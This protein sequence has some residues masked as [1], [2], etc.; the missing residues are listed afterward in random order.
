MKSRNFW[1][2]MGVP[3]TTFQSANGHTEYSQTRIERKLCLRQTDTDG[4]TDRQGT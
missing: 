4:Q 3:A 1:S 2:G